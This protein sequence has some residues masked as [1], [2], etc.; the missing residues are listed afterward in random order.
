[1]IIII[2]SSSN[3]KQIHVSRQTNMETGGYFTEKT[4]D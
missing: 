3:N 2:I 1:M 4:L